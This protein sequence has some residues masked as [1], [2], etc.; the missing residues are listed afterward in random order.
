[1]ASVSETAPMG[2][3]LPWSGSYFSHP[4]DSTY[5]VSL[6][7]PFLTPTRSASRILSAQNCT[8]PCTV[9]PTSWHFLT[10]TPPPSGPKWPSSHVHPPLSQSGLYG[11][12][13]ISYFLS[14]AQTLSSVCSALIPQGPMLMSLPCCTLLLT[15]VASL[16]FPLV[17]SI[18]PLVSFILVHLDFYLPSSGTY[19]FLLP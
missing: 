2:L 9:K 5:S 16:L 8:H 19:L 11:C 7:Q 15:G 12:P 4:N 18:S 17:W 6:Q 3:L 1:M 14:C 13:I 10:Q